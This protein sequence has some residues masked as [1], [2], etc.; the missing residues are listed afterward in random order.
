LFSENHAQSQELDFLGVTSELLAM[1]NKRLGTAVEPDQ[2][3]FADGLITSLFA[4]ELVVQIE[5]TFNVFIEGP[6]LQIANF[7]TVNHMAHLIFRLAT[8]S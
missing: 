7:R 1:V 8:T 6:D 5:N 2:D 4:L 3:L